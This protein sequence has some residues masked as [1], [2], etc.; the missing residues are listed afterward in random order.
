MPSLLSIVIRYKRL[1]FLA[2]ALGF[3]VSAAVSLI[4]PPRYVASA[5]LA[6]VGVEKE[7]TGLRGF[8]APL[9]SF[10]E[11]FA[12]YLRAQ[13]NFIFEL[14][15]RSRRMSELLDARFDLKDAYGVSDADEVRRRL[16]ENTSV[17][18]R[19]E[20]VIALSVEDRSRERA[21]A[22][23][24]GYLAV[25]DSILTDLT[26]E[27]S[28]ERAAF[29][30]EEIARRTAASAVADSTLASYLQ[31]FGLYHVE[32]QVRAMLDIVSDLSTRLSVLDIEEKLLEMTMKPGSD[33]LDRVSFER[34]KLRE[35]LFLL[36]ETGA[37]PGLFP[38][39][40][41]LPE[42]SARYGHLIGE[43]QMDE[44]T[45]AYLRVR[46]AEA[47]LSAASR[48]SAIRIL[49]PPS[50]PERRS[51]PKRKQI[52]MIS[53]AAAFLWACFFALVRERWKAGAS[54]G[55]IPPAA[56]PDRRPEA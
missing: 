43:R 8:F 25:L 39:L 21:I 16:R 1:I 41:K 40:K 35:Q 55:G 23:A 22:I 34:R 20:G 24:E 53:T 50:A 7:L 46:L 49:D 54:G 56:S 30:E 45:L 10:G 36:R 14:L 2:T 38:P 26:I 13:K 11:S 29:L 32:Q 3:V 31:Q 4:I 33:E 12:T 51:W 28:L 42:I 52:V 9:G 19:D 15:I 6:P 47:R 5:M 27:S 48:V 37:E 18:I 17:V 44:F